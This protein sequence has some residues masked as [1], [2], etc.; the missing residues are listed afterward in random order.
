MFNQIFVSYLNQE[1]IL[2]PEQSRE[3][4][5]VQKNTRIR[6]GVLAEEENLM[7]SQQTDQVNRLQ[8]SQNARFGDIAIQKDFLTQEQLDALLKKQ[9][10]EHIILKQILCDKGYLDSQQADNAL[11]GFKSSLGVSDEDFSLLQ[12]GNIEAYIKHIA[13]IDESLMG[14]FAKMF[15]TLTFRLID[16]EVMVKEAYKTTLA[17]AKYIV[18][19][20]CFG[21]AEGF[22]SFSSAD[23]ASAI[24]FAEAYSKFT[25]DT[26]DEDARESLKEF[27]NCVCGLV[28]SELSNS[29]RMELDIDVPAYFDDLSLGREVTVLPFSIPIGEFCVF[30]F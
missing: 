12:D 24:K 21:D 3:V 6:I 14:E 29:G 11:D 13:K 16:R 8:T 28:I 30:I 17:S 1:K 20:R 27:M 15:I 5:E 23:S 10:R 22:F 26:L 19:Q 7:T 25:L 18:T 9:P 2:S 4:L